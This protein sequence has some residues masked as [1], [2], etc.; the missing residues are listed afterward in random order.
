MSNSFL[1]SF[2]GIVRPYMHDP[3]GPEAY[4]HYITLVLL[5]LGQLQAVTGVINYWVD[6]QGDLYAWIGSFADESFAPRDL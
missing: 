5:F 4:H 2:F 3:D 1:L 6:D